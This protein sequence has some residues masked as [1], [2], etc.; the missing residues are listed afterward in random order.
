ME[1]ELRTKEQGCKGYIEKF[2]SENI[3]LINIYIQKDERILIITLRILQSSGNIK[4][5]EF[6]EKLCVSKNTILKELDVIQENLKKYK[7]NL[8]RKSGSGLHVEGLEIDKRNAVIDIIS[9]SVSVE[10]VVNYVSNRSSQSKIN[11]LQFDSLFK[12]I[13]IDFIDRLI[14]NAEVNLKREFSDQAYGGLITHLAIMIKRVQIGKVIS[15][16]AVNND[17]AKNTEEYQVT[18]EIIRSIEEKYNIEVPSQEIS[19]I[20]I[21]LLGAKVVNNEF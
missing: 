16:P 7:L 1:R 13:D 15:D 6:E 5:K 18:K 8:V 20:V 2:S 3:L 14:K 12:E 4:M 17:F 21:H 10:D 11:I 19:Y 9:Q